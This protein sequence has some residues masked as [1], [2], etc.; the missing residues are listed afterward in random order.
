LYK[1]K[2]NLVKGRIEPWYHLHLQ[3]A[4][5]LKPVTWA[6]SERTSRHVIRLPL[7]VPISTNHRL[8]VSFRAAT[9]DVHQCYEYTHILLK[10]RTNVKVGMGTSCFCKKKIHSFV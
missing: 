6:T 2:S 4:A 10:G 7:P 1:K 9:L 8:S 5:C 3:A